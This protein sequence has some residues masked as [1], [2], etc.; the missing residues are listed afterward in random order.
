MQRIVVQPAG[1]GAAGLADL[2]QWLGISQTAEDALLADLLG[3]A[4]DLCEAFTGQ[5]PL[6]Q[7][8]EVLLPPNPCRHELGTRPV[9]E[10]LAVDVIAPDQS[11]TALA[12]ADYT[13]EIA[14]DGTAHL[15]LL[16]AQ[17]GRALA[18]RLSVG[19][20]ADWA[21]LPPALRQG[22]IRLAAHG[23]R[24]RD[25]DG[26][27]PRVSTPP[28]SVIALWQRWRLMRLA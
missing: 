28:A 4:L 19:I 10:V 15:R 8:I 12:E 17:P 3:T 13:A 2:K 22:I 20:A 9:R 25:R 18:V 16:T 27:G 1:I 24:D 5:A 21:S 7:T 23:Y 14:A 11:R 26:A 6:A